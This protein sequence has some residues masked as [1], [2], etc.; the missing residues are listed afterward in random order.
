MGALMSNDR[1]KFRFTDTMSNMRGNV[2]AA[3]QAFELDERQ[4]RQM[5]D[6]GDTIICRPSQFARFLILRSGLVAGNCFKQ[7]EAELFIPAPDSELDV[8]TRPNTYTAP[9]KH[10]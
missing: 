7:L 5:F 10:V 8:S 3:V 6:R 2:T 4:A 9:V 1:V